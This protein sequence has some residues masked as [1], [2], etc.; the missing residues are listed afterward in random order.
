MKDLVDSL[1][2]LSGGMINLGAKMDYYSG[3]DARIAR[4]GQELVAAGMAA[5]EWAD[6]IASIARAKA[7]AAP[8]KP[9]K[10]VKPHHWTP[11]D[12]QRLAELYPDADMAVLRETFGRSE[13]AI[14]HRAK[15]LGVARAN[16]AISRALSQATRAAKRGGKKPACADEPVATYARRAQALAVLRGSREVVPVVVDGRRRW[17]LAKVQE[18]RA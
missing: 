1:K 13:K 5:R 15:R 18:K 11:E 10:P 14:R 7:A 17:R 16:E 6:D 3:F 9:A 8:Q 2:R 4:R 12:D